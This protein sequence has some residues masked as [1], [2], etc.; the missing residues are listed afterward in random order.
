MPHKNRITRHKLKSQTNTDQT[1]EGYI[2]PTQSKGYKC[3]NQ[4]SLGSHMVT[5]MH[6]FLLS[7]KIREK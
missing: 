2:G 5:K 3:L 6:N 7:A 1:M 4:T